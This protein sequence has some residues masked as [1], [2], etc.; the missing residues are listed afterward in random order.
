MGSFE[1]AWTTSLPFAL[2]MPIEL[3]GGA[4]LGGAVGY[5]ATPSS[6]ARA[7]LP[8]FA[9]WSLVAAL[10]F[11]LMLLGEWLSTSENV[12]QIAAYGKTLSVGALC[13]AAAL[14]AA[15]IANKRA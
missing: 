11:S 3:V 9:E 4:A 1:K 15:T 6:F 10:L 12:W 7:M 2:R 13:G 8:V 5:W 14:A